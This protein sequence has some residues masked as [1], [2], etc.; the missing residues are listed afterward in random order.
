M[1][2]YYNLV[3]A[4]LVLESLA[5][6]V[7]ILP[8][9]YAWRRE[10]LRWVS[11]S[12]LIAR[13]QYALK[14]AFVFVFILFIDTTNRAYNMQHENNEEH[15]HDSRTEANY[16]AK[17]FYNQR[18]MYLTGFTLFLSLILNR[19][20]VLIVEL[21]KS[22]DQLEAVK[23]QAANQSKEYLRL[24]DS[25]SHLQKEVEKLTGELEEERKKTRDHETLKKQANQ[26]HDEYMRLSDR[27]NELLKK[28]ENHD[29]D[30]KSK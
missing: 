13:S 26:V 10:M 16:H 8:L 18:N 19:T 1:T 12:S 3:F 15:V 17:K 11:Q 28:V 27:Y 6:V 23:K 29:E 22:E 14:F 24:N 2:L 25:E 7:L 21:L 20:Y 4:L 9:P 30:D 5:F